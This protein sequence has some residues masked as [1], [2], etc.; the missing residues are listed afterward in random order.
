VTG[1][2]LFINTTAARAGP[3]SATTTSANIFQASGGLINLD[4]MNGIS[5]TTGS[6]HSFFT[7]VGSAGIAW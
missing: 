4:G 5:I 3:I 7:N 1:G 6:G 2:S